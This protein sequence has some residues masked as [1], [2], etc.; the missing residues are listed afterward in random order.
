MIFA[1]YAYSINTGCSTALA[2]IAE[3]FYRIGLRVLIVDWDLEIPGLEKYFDV[4]LDVVRK[5]S[6]IIDMLLAYKEK[7]S[8][9]IS[10]SD[11]RD[12]GSL[13]IGVEQYLV[14]IHSKSNDG[15][16]SI[17]TAGNRSDISEYKRKVK[18][19]DWVEFYKDWDGDLFLR[20]MKNDFDRLAD[21]VLIDTPNGDTELG[22]SCIYQFADIVL[23]FLAFNYQ[24]IEPTYQMLKKI[25]GT[26]SSGNSWI[27]YQSTYYPLQ[28]RIWGTSAALRVL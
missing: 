28:S 23:M 18:N 25:L 14:Q 11:E 4:D 27:S 2:N 6:G 9:G 7:M 22:R 19:F 17:L 16:L 8:K 24:N 21:V 15:E 20:L 13:F 1:F 5:K 10:T 3:I 12:K 26:Q